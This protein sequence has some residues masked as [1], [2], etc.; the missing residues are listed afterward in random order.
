MKKFTRWLSK[1]LPPKRNDFS[2]SLKKNKY[3][4]KPIFDDNM[5][6]RAGTVEALKEFKDKK[7]SE[8][9]TIVRFVAMTELI[10]QLSIVYEIECPMICLLGA[11]N[12]G[13]TYLPKKNIIVFSRLDKE[14]KKVTSS[15]YSRKSNFI[16]LMNESL[17]TLLHEFGHARGFGEY[18]AVKFSVSLFKRVYP[19]QFDKLKPK[20][21]MLV[22]K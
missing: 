19:K 7:I 17:I 11:N 21:H 5:K 3:P 12:T 20:N 22:R 4:K 14:Y 10:K 8:E 1:P 16:F 13:I 18:K 6:F 9:N 15:F 2:I